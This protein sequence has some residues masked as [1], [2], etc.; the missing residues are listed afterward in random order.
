[1]LVVSTTGVPM[2]QANNNPD[3]NTLTKVGGEQLGQRITR[4]LVTCVML[5]AALSKLLGTS[6]SML[7]QQGRPWLLAWQ[8]LVILVEL[9]LAFWLVLPHGRFFSWLAVFMLFLVFTGISGSLAWTGQ[10]SCECFGPMKTSPISTLTMDLA[11][12]SLLLVFRPQWTAWRNELPSVLTAGFI[13]AAL[14]IFGIGL[15]WHYGSIQAGVAVLR[16]EE[17]I[18]DS[19]VIDFGSAQ[20]RDILEHQIHFRNNSNRELRFTGATNDCSCHFEDINIR[21]APGDTYTH[22]VKLRIPADTKPGW[23]CRSAEVYTNSTTNGLVVFKL[24]CVIEP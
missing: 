13:F 3:T 21:L 15:R 19:Q 23:F 11:I 4:W 16:G 9:L 2:S 18:V 17:L 22:T 10:A 24:C 7:S 14:L 6:E 20:C 8:H 1:M 5:F 12:L